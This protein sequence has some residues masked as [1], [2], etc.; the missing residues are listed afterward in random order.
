M[1]SFLLIPVVPFGQPFFLAKLPD[2]FRYDKLWALYYH[3]TRQGLQFPLQ[4]HSDYLVELAW[5][6]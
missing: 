6:Y 3:L 4:C 2:R 5:G 1:T